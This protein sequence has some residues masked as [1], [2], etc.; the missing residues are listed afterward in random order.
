MNVISPAEISTKLYVLPE[1]LLAKIDAYIDQLLDE[2]QI[3]GQGSSSA[4]G[5]LKGKIWIAPDFDDTPE[6]FEEYI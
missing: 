2:M 6:C 1:D 5:A 3:T 4:F